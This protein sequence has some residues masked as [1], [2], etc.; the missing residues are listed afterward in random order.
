VTLLE[1][2]HNIVADALYQPL[3][4]DLARARHF[5]LWCR[6]C[7]LP[8]PA[9]YSVRS[10]RQADG[11]HGGCATRP[12]R[13]GCRS[14]RRHPQDR[15]V[16]QPQPDGGAVRRRARPARADHRGPDHARV[17]S[18]HT[19]RRGAGE[20]S[21]QAWRVPPLPLAAHAGSTDPDAV[22]DLLR[23]P[24]K[25][26]RRLAD[27][28]ARRLARRDL[29]RSALAVDPAGGGERASCRAGHAA[30]ACLAPTGC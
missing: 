6:P 28:P 29:R 18:Q 30:P 3:T 24:R 8:C 20:L 13:D 4:A 27:P 26:D 14:P 21:H 5:V 11:A 19:D 16:V 9:A 1:R 23:P 17:L 10:I 15:S 7:D 25:W 22:G 2:Q 12:C